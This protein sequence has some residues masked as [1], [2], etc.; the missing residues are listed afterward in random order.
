V[1]EP[2][3]KPYILSVINNGVF[4]F[5]KKQQATKN[6]MFNDVDCPMVPRFIVAANYYRYTREEARHVLGEA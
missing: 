5:Y 6:S 3:V 4:W 2:P 1:R